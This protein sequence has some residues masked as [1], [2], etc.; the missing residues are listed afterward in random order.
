MRPV[1]LVLTGAEG[2]GTR[3]RA[4]LGAVPASLRLHRFPD[5]E[6]RVRIEGDLS[7]RA[8]ILLASLDRPDAKLVPLL[9]AAAT[10]RELGARSV[11]LVAPYLPY[12]RQDLAFHRGESVGA[13]HFAGILSA[14]VDWLL[15][16]D[17]H[18]HRVRR[19]DELFTVPAEA[20]HAAPAIA[21]WIRAEV[22]D[23]LV[24]GPDQESE[25]WVEAV[26]RGAD[27]PWA[28]L[29]KHRHGDRKVELTLPDL[30]VPAGRR[31]VL[32]DDII[33]TGATMRQAV[34]LLR[35]AGSPAPWCVAVHAVFAGDAETELRRAGAREV[36]TSNTLPH[37]T[38]RLD[39]LPAL[40]EGVRGI[41]ARAPAARMAGCP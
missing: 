9:F 36:V 34:A 25:Q 35:A 29:T 12:M 33:S 23:P 4:S 32:V 30:G 26:A 10:A 24:L 18:L 39:V 17:P 16:V 22:R 13:R 11:G 31:P 28:V 19:L 37:P 5:G 27:A 3:L 2:L 14:S 15:T 21:A 38:N 20:V 7:G 1:V 6:T 8:V 41:L 40:V